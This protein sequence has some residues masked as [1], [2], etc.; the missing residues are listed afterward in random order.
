MKY[1]GTQDYDHAG[2]GTT[3]VLL[4]N[5]GTPEAAEAGAV[6]RYLAEFL[7][8]PR[9]IEVPAVLWWGILH[10]IIL[11][12][13]PRRSAV[14]YRKIWQDDGSP[15]LLHTLQQARAL[16]EHLRG[17]HV[18]PAMRYGRPSVQDG[19]ERLRAAGV[20]RL[21]LLPVY[22][23]YSATTTASAFDA[24][25][26]ALRRWRW[27]PEFRMVLHY[28][29]HPDYIRALA[30]S[31]REYR[32]QQGAGERLLFSFHGIPGHYFLAG[33]P[34]HCECHK[35][36]RLVADAL[37]LGADEWAVSFQSRLGPRAWLKPYTD[38]VLTQWARGGIRRTDVVCPGFAA[39]CLET[40]EEVAIRYR[41][42]F[43]ARGGE[44]LHYIPALN[45]RADHIEMLAALVA[46]HAWSEPLTADPQRQERARQRGA[47]R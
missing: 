13:R 15:L 43:V 45:A 23:Q 20:R 19:L 38:K 34:Y 27:L 2:V 37:G 9:V 42:L 47:R 1:A 16:H 24:V 11:R 17:M 7:S 26:R 44:S 4:V 40:L 18:E 8:D 36:A 41:E 32:A 10:G 12:L 14:A 21:L 6:R 33:D 25:T 28:H 3:G 35:T 39:D 30:A 22:P 31:V 46:T 29:D 5:L